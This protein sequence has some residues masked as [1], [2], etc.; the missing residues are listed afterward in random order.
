M[1][2][3]PSRQVHLDFH[4]S[5][6]IDGIGSAFDKKQFQSCLKK[7]HV[8]SITIFAKCH[9]GWAYFPSKTC[10]VHPGLKFDLLSSMLEAC[11]EI[12]V[13][14]PIYISAGLDENY[15]SIHPDHTLQPRRGMTYPKTGSYNG[16]PY[17]IEETARWHRLC[18]NTPYFDK[19]ISQV[20]EV[21]STFDPVGIFLDI[22]SP[23]VCYCPYCQEK[24]KELG[25]DVEDDESFKRLAEITYKKYYTGVNN[26]AK[27]IKPGVRIFHNGG[28]I[29][30]GRRDLAYANTHLELESLPTGGWGYDHFPKSAKYVHN[31]G[32]EYLGMTGKFHLTWGEFGGFKHPNA[33]KY[34]AALSVACGAKCSVGD[35]MHPYAFLDDAT[36][37]LIGEAYKEVELIENYCFDTK[38]IADIGIISSESFSKNDLDRNN[39]ADIGVCRILLEGHYLFDFLDE[40]CSLDS[41]KLLILPDRIVLDDNMKKKLSD[42]V[43]KGG[44]LLCSGD[45]GTDA[46]G[47]SIFNLGSKITKRSTYTPTYYKPTYPALGLSP[48][49]YV[50][51]SALNE[52]E[53]TSDSKI[54]GYAN[55]PFFNRTAEH[56][57]SHKHTPFNEKNEIPAVTIGKDGA[58][59]AYSIFGEYANVG[60]II[61]KD[62]VHK[63][64]EELIGETKTLSTNLPSQGVACYNE[65]AG[66]GRSVLHLLFATPVKR[67]NG[68]E[69]I[70]DLIPIT[71]TT[72][73]LR[74]KRKA[75]SVTL[76]PQMTSLDFKQQDDIISFTV[77]SFTCN[78]VISIEWL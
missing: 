59:I 71:E 38:P 69:V 74:D 24:I 29:R 20:E 33:L 65:Q 41:Y 52:T 26:A 21:V 48:T 62:I 42:F 31:L 66:N 76:I 55:P 39:S 34:E 3:L 68:V 40:D 61:A 70:E 15:A 67:G 43:A 28:H 57:C 46:E 13:Q 77:E 45:S 72:V 47:N 4:T 49:N 7:G 78:Q 5:G 19:L 25:W 58:Y 50:V 51:Y 36:Y 32:M 6:Q 75:K 54:L 10:D 12:D 22:V 23:V 11:A 14:A 8:N 56:F 37:E 1:F 9:H 16:L 63:V 18:M 64:I 44:K 17:V 53:L 27:A 73:K 60:S 35:Q 2:K 30:A